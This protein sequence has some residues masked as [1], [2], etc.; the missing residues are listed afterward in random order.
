MNSNPIRVDI[1]FD[2]PGFGRF[3][4]A[5]VFLGEVN[6]VVDTGPASCADNL[7]NALDSLGV[8]RVDRVLLTHIHIDHSGGLA[9][10]LARYP[11]ARVICH[12]KGLKF[13]V[14]PTKLWEGSVKVLKD[15]AEDYGPPPPV[16]AD[17]LVSHLQADLDGLTVLETPGHA[18]HHLS[19]TWQGRLLSGEAAGNLLEVDGRPYLRPATPPRF[20][21]PEALASVD[22][23]LA[24][25]D[26]PVHYAH[27]S[28]VEQAHP[29]IQRYRDQLFRWEDI[30]ARAAGDEVGE[31][32][33]SPEL[34][35]RVIQALLD[36]DPELADFKKM[37]L[38]VQNREKNFMANSVRGFLGYLKEKQS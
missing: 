14:N 19:F 12:D 1:N 16:A 34:T 27:Y 11:E 31:S 2:R 33:P 15:L 32:I 4:V 36:E 8:D 28:W 6:L 13:L 35:R 26:G 18:P 10:I 9:A 21:M 22:K 37:D 20:F 38:S 24:L 29:M 7:L 5:W 17:R 3:F 23:L 25:P 30:I